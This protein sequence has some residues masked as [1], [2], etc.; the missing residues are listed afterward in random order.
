MEF[1]ALKE[2]FRR[3]EKHIRAR[4]DAVLAHGQF[5]MGPEV[6]ELESRL[7]EMVG[8]KHC[9][10]CASGTSAL[11][12]V[13][14]AWEV[15]PG[16]AVFTTPF[17]FFATA[18]SIAKTGATPV[19]VDI[20]PATFNLNATDLERAVEAVLRRDDRLYPL[21]R[22]AQAGNPPLRP[23]AVVVV[24]IFGHP[25]DYD[26]ILPFARKCG[27]SVLED[28]AQSFGGVYRGKPLC[29][30][31]CDAATASFFPAKPLGCYGDGG[32]VFT[33]DD[34]L[35][36][37]VDSLRYHGRKDS[38]N[39][40]DN[41]RLGTNGRLDTLQ[42][43][44]LL[45]KLD[46]FENELNLRNEVAKRYGA[47]LCSLPDIVCPKM[48]LDGRSAWAQYS[49]LLPKY[50]SR[51]TCIRAMKKD[52]IPTSVFYPKGL[53]IQNALDYLEYK[54]EDFPVVQE[55]TARVLSL[56]MHPYLTEIE[57][58]AVVASL[59]KALSR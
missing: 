43:A 19:F 54:V 12:L 7:S 21:P 49:I 2:Q 23:K 27:M 17:S 28:A 6:R 55:V 26:A 41:V 31:G 29:G 30:C 16:D 1:I 51:E 10:T 35:A 58:Q 59:G 48:P 37:C 24:D 39:K 53:H 42:A 32:A 45:A 52:A 40:N 9:L 57:Q 11:D 3:H 25:A 4:M 44:I 33:D 5:I 56:P 47:L 50:V 36:G 8:T 18:E 20:E 22:Q 34:A 13:M 14:M 46:I 38:S 15:G